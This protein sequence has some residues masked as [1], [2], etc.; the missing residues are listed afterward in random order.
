ML[1]SGTAKTI[2]A[3]SSRG[4]VSDSRRSPIGVG[5][6]HP[7]GWKDIW[8][9]KIL[10]PLQF[11]ISC[12]L[13]PPENRRVEVGATEGLWQVCPEGSP[14]CC[15]LV[16]VVQVGEGSSALNLLCAKE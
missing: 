1:E 5:G 6:P 13:E 10:I 7:Y 4:S 8:L 9:K 14:I 16:P 15:A 2:S 12:F 11:L 3:E